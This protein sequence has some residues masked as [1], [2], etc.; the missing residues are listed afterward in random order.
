MHW[1]SLRSSGDARQLSNEELLE[2]DV[3]LLIPA[4][5]ENQITEQ[6]ADRIKAPVIV[7]I[8]NGPIALDAETILLKKGQSSSCPMFWPM[9][10]A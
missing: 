7:E 5:M 4:A 3:D 1:F 6:N 8:A 9:L 2:L 10:A